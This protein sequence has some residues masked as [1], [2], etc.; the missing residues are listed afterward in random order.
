MI[1]VLKNKGNELSFIIRGINSN[2]ANTIRRFSF[3]IPVLAV[4]TVEISKNDSVLYDEILA[5]R[6][7]LISLKTDKTF[8]LPEKCTCKG[9]G[10]AKCTANL[11][12]KITGPGMIKADELK[13]K[14]IKIIYPETPLVLL[15]ENQELEL[16]AEARLGKSIQHAKY[17]SGLMWFRAYP[18]IEISKDCDS[19]KECA[20]VCPKNVYSTD[21][22]ISVKNMINCDLCN[23]C[24]EACSR[25]GKNAIKISGSEEDFIFEIEGWGQL[26]PKEIFI[27]SLEVLKESLKELDKEINKL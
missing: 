22:K 13:S 16:I 5:H 14:T 3:E 11:T 2:F 23:A 7:G 26:A 19:C 20:R 9:K 1:E 8:T 10:C 15:Q 4:D 18:K 24:V 27:I 21:G 25:K 12:L 17:S 6:I